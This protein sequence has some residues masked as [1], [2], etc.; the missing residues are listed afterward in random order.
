[1]RRLL[2]RLRHLAPVA[3]LLFL[4][5][6]VVVATP[7]EA[8]AQVR[9]LAL[10]GP[11]GISTERPLCESILRSL[12]AE[13]FRQAPDGRRADPRFVAWELL[14]IQTIPPGQIYEYGADFHLI[15][16]ARVD[17]LN[18]GVTR[19]MYRVTYKEGYNSWEQLI[20]FMRNEGDPVPEIEASGR[21]WLEVLPE[22][23]IEIEGLVFGKDFFRSGSQ[24]EFQSAHP[25]FTN[26]TGHYFDHHFDRGMKYDRRNPDRWIDLMITEEGRSLSILET[27]DTVMVLEIREKTAKPICYFARDHEERLLEVV[28]PASGRE[29]ETTCLKIASAVNAEIESVLANPGSSRTRVLYFNADEEPRASSLFLRWL[30]AYFAP[31][32][33]G[34]SSHFYFGS[35]RSSNQIGPYE[36]ETIETIEANILNDGIL[37]R[38][39]RYTESTMLSSLEL[40]SQHLI[41]QADNPEGIAGAPP[42]ET[43]W[44]FRH[45]AGRG[46]Y[47]D[48]E[49]HFL[50]PKVAGFFEHG[51]YKAFFEKFPPHATAL[52]QRFKTEFATFIHGGS[53]GY[54]EKEFDLIG[55]EDGRVLVLVERRRFSA[56]EQPMI[57]V[58]ELRPDRA[59]PVCYLG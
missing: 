24:R 25:A 44:W 31:R 10:A 59:I 16:T 42:G 58:L 14:T 40:F 6:G 5:F 57:L 4:G 7:Q 23:I 27:G 52:G 13:P 3:I 17:I 26:F 1:M 8:A 53:F 2:E 47:R 41:F 34:S 22:N 46:I 35:G 9:R 11:A 15:D 55:L 19:T 32:Y 28:G 21:Q 37:R 51:D 20:F 45:F 18:N 30:P 36:N 50:G 33:V 49:G 29:L 54:G 43:V 48:V 38:V 56:R 39:F 12:N